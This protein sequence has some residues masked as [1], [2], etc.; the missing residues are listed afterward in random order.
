MSY[1]SGP[2]IHY[3]RFMWENFF[4]HVDIDPRNVHIPDGTLSRDEVPAFCDA[5][6][7]AIQQAGGIDFQLLGIGKT[8][9]I[10]FN[11]PGSGAR[12]RTRLITLDTITRRD[13]AGTSSARTTSSRGHHDGYRD[14]PRAREIAILATGSTRPASC[15]VPSRRGGHRG[16][17]HVPPAPSEYDVLPRRRGGCHAHACGDVAPPS[18]STLQASRWSRRPSLNW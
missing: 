3:H 17:R 18:T 11:E 4:S 14:D 13:A 16:C 12:S 7:A 8:G 2:S 15:G 6:E 9:H 1:A 5:Y 10:G